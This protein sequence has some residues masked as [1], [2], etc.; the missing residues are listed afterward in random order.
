METLIGQNA[1]DGTTREACSPEG[2]KA[3]AP[4]KP[5]TQWGSRDDPLATPY[6][7]LHPA[8]YIEQKPTPS[9]P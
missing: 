7:G 3:K 6:P 8:G 9:N 4:Q 5:A 1:G 2:K